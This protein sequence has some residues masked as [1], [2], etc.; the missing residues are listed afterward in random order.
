MGRQNVKVDYRVAGTAGIDRCV[1][2]LTEKPNPLFAKGFRGAKPM[3]PTP[4]G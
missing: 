1:P 3:V 2:G 4:R